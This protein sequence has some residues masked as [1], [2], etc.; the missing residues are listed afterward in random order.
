MSWAGAPSRVSNRSTRR[1]RRS[2]RSR[3]NSSMVTTPV[4][5]NPAP[6]RRG[7]RAESQNRSH[8]RFRDSTIRSHPF[9]LSTW[10]SAPVP[11]T[12]GATVSAAWSASPEIEHRGLRPDRHPAIQRRSH[13]RCRSATKAASADIPAHRLRNATA[14]HLAACARTDNADRGWVVLRCTSHQAR[15]ARSS[16]NGTKPPSGPTITTACPG[17]MSRRDYALP[18]WAIHRGGPTVHPA[19]PPRLRNSSCADAFQRHQRCRWPDHARQQSILSFACFRI[20]S[21]SH[22]SPPGRC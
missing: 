4:P 9:T 11:R 13:C 19:D 17:G 7:R 20:G 15:C 18:I 12:V 3:G 2:D 8:P 1:P 22:P 10:W 21:A 16:S 14:H 5:G 6:D